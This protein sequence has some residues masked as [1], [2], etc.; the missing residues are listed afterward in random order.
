MQQQQNN[1]KKEKNNNNNWKEKKKE[2][3]RMCDSGKLFDWENLFYFVRLFWTE[4]ITKKRKKKR[5]TEKVEK[6]D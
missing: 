2:C 4:K 1:I 5:N 6:E 3:T